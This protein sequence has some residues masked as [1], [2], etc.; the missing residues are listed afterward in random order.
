MN[1]F[2]ITGGVA[3]GL[4]AVATLVGATSAQSAGE[5]PAITEEAAIE[6][7]LAEVAG[8]VTETELEHEDG[9]QV[10]EIEIVT[11]EGVEM[12]IEIDAATGAVLEVEAEDDDDDDDRKDD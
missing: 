6:I 9:K 2:S 5:A 10:Y 1:K 11:A 4:L 3:A 12:E 7:A 8:K